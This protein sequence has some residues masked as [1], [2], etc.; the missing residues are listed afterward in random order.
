MKKLIHEVVCEFFFQDLYKMMSV[1]KVIT[2]RKQS[3]LDITITKYLTIF[4]GTYYTLDTVLGTEDKTVNLMVWPLLPLTSEF[5]ELC[6]D[7]LHFITVLSFSYSWSSQ[8]KIAC[9]PSI[10]GNFTLIYIK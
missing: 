3:M 2:H 10:I 5:S 9:S 8:G 6:F 4:L 1:L 7:N